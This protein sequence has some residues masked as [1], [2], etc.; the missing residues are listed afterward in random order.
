MINSGLT[1]VA[2]PEMI[3]FRLW[4][5]IF[6]AGPKVFLCVDYF[7][8]VFWRHFGAP[9][10]LLRRIWFKVFHLYY[11]EVSLGL[12]ACFSTYKFC[13]VKS[14][15]TPVSP[16]SPVFPQI[17][18]FPK[19]PFSPNLMKIHLKMMLRSLC[20][21]KY[22]RLRWHQIFPWEEIYADGSRTFEPL[23]IE[24]ISGNSQK[25][26]REGAIK[27]QLLPYHSGPQ[28]RRPQAQSLLCCLSE[29]SP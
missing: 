29:D 27:I 19:S 1:C 26:D 28:T 20:W 16:K 13:H 25:L 9:S 6:T 7:Q 24:A 8:V 5:H 17:S 23:A 22:R 14:A 3:L 4:S 11:L 10:L 18:G 21:V 2:A 15:T 12:F